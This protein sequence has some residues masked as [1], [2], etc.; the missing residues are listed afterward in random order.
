MHYQPPD[1]KAEAAKG[2]SFV[3]RCFA[4]SSLD[5]RLYGYLSILVVLVY[6]PVVHAFFA[7]IYA[8]NH[9]VAYVC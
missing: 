5:S 8:R 6:A 3:W 2:W 7:E 1:C 9:T 4:A